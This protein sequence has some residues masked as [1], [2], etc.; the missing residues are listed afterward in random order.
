MR[1]CI[2]PFTVSSFAKIY[3][4]KSCISPL[5][6]DG[7]D[8]NIDW[9]PTTIIDNMVSACYSGTYFDQSVYN[10]WWSRILPVYL[11]F[12]ELF[13]CIYLVIRLGFPSLEWLQMTK[14]VL[15]NCVIKRVLPFQNI[16][17]DLDPSYKMDLDLWDC[18]GREK[19]PSYNQ[20]NMIHLLSFC[21]CFVILRLE[22]KY[23]RYY[24]SAGVGD[25]KLTSIL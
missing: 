25:I 8:P 10:I 12:V 16:P 3:L 1:T 24:F 4:Y 18:F 7:L 13:L 5:S 22:Q 14:S 15:W 21:L 6:K 9:W 2:Q 17:K 23:D 19:S 20:R 11:G